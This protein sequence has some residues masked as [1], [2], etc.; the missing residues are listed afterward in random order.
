MGVPQGSI[1]GPVLFQIY[2]NDLVK[3]SDILF[4]ILIS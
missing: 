3:G 2:V 4:F 1:L